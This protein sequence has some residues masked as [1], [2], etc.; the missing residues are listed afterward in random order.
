MINKI[1]TTHIQDIESAV[2]NFWEKKMRIF[3]SPL[4]KKEKDNINVLTI[5]V[6]IPGS[7][8][9]FANQ[10]VSSHNKSPHGYLLKASKLSTK[11][12]HSISIKFF[13]FFPK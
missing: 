6:W 4:P 3:Y 9:L 2:V 13:S 8:K 7:P 1:Q 11:A 5:S 12:T 10:I